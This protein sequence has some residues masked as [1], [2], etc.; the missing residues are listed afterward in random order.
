MERGEAFAK[1]APGIKET[2]ERGLAKEEPI[3]LKGV[4]SVFAMVLRDFDLMFVVEELP[5]A[6]RDALRQQ[7]QQFVD[8]A[9]AT[10]HGTIAV[11]FAKATGVS[12]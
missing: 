7:T 3:L 2:M 5:D 8:H 6:R 1:I 4:Q 9:L 10:Y 11:E 12:S